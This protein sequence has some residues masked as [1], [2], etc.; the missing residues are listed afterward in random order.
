[1]FKPPQTII[2]AAGDGDFVPVIERAKGKG[3]GGRG[4]VLGQRREGNEGSR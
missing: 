2:I 4:V 3:W 1:M